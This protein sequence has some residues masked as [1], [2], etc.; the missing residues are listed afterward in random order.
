MALR[1]IGV[2]FRRYCIKRRFLFGVLVTSIS[3]IGCLLLFSSS[4]SGGFPTVSNTACDYPCASRLQSEL[5]NNTVKSKTEATGFASTE[6][7]FIRERKTEN[8][9]STSGILNVHFWSEICGTKVDILRNWPHFPYFPDK[10]SSISEFKY[11]QNPATN[12][13]G[14]RIFGFVHPQKSGDYKFAIASDDTSELWLSPNEDPASSEMIARVYSP[15]ESAWTV[16]GDYM[17]YAEQISKE[18]TLHAGKK[19]YIESLLKQGSGSAHVAV[20][21]SYRNQST[22]KMI[23]SKYLSSFSK[24]NDDAPP[25]AGKQR[26]ILLQLKRN[27]FYFNRLPIVNRKEYAD[28]M[29]TCPYSPTFLVR[30]KLKKYESIWFTKESQVFPRDD[31]EVT[32]T[33]KKNEW[34]RAN[35]AADK[36]TVEAVVDKFMKFLPSG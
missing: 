1:W 36:G 11:T 35:T 10:R 29:T 23:S 6:R 28:L 24:I 4:D 19:Y 5:N 20:Y 32:N 7:T 22:F 25:H 15:N 9:S 16:D 34:T 12:N 18:I 13:N 26:N 21:W 8:D 14:Q 17:K 33:V 27:L 3:F 31:T 2:R 30:K